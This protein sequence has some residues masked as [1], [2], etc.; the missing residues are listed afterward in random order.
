MLPATVLPHQAALFDRAA[1]RPP[2]PAPDLKYYDILLANLSG[3]KDSQTMLRALVKAADDAGVRDRIVCVFADLGTADEWPGA[4]E[5][6]ARHAAAYGLRFIT[7]RREVPD[8][9]TG[10]ARPQGLLEH[11][12]HRGMWPDARNRYCTSD[13]KRGPIRTV[14]TFLTTEARDQGITGRRVRILNVM[15]MRAQESPAR[16]LLAPF[17]FDPPASNKTRREVHQWLPVHDWTAD[18]VWADIRSSGIPYHW[19]YDRGM[20]RLSCRFCVM[21]SES[22]LVLAAQLDPAGAAARAVVEREFLRRKAVTALAILLETRRLGRPTPALGYALKRAL[23]SGHKFQAAR[24]MEQIIA[25]AKAQ[26]L[27]AAVEDW[28]A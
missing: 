6:A 15:G 11:I 10:Q 27:P 23:R 19:V 7:V 24:S 14:M 9:A 16:R 4:A 22:A 18:E 12:V 25:K 28:Q 21:S 3:G 5:L 20:P 2:S 26:P 13:T 1:V 17:A 8:P